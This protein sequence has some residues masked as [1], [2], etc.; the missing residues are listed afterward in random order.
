MRHLFSLFVLMAALFA[1]E[2]ALSQVYLGASYGVAEPTGD[3]PANRIPE[4]DGDAGYRVYLGNRLSEKF[5]M[6]VAYVDLGE[7]EVGSVAGTPDP[8]ELRDTLAITGIDASVLGKLPLSQRLA[9]FARIGIFSWEG[10]RVIEDATTGQLGTFIADEIDYNAGL[11]LEYRYMNYLGFTLEFNNY[12][13][14]EIDN[15]LYGAGVYFNF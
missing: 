12:H 9:V 10:E 7:Y 11:G 1:T 8:T 15:Y 2:I 6:E 13:S 14:D 3:D 4:M 5:A